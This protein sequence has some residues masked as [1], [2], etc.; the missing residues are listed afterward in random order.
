MKIISRR[1]EYS[2]WKT[3]LPI[4]PLYIGSNFIKMLKESKSRPDQTE[5]TTKKQSDYTNNQPNKQTEKVGQRN[6]QTK[7]LSKQTNKIL[8]KLTKKQTES[9][10]SLFFVFEKKCKQK[11]M[12]YVHIDDHQHPSPH[13]DQ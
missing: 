13:L 2:G 7:T 9:C 6:K 3:V 10:S 5:Q 11:G 4:Y 1:V 12:Q 8:E